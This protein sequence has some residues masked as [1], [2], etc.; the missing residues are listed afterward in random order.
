MAKR[1]GG[2]TVRLDKGIGVVGYGSVVGQKEGSGP[3]GNLFDEVV[4]DSKPL[5]GSWEKSESALQSAA[6]T[7]ALGRAGL[8]ADGVDM[9]FAGDLLNQCI[10]STFGL[11]SYGI[12]FAGLFGACSTMALS[13]MMAAISVESGAAQKAAAVTS[14]HFCTAERQFRTPLEYGGQRTPT[15]QWTTTAAGAVV[16]GVGGRVSV[17]D[18]CMGKIVD[19]G[20]SDAN[21]MGA[22]MAPAACDTIVSYMRDTGTSPDDYDAVFTGDLGSV[23]SELLLELVTA[24]GYTLDSK[25]LDCGKMIFDI[26]RQ[27]VH[28]GGSGCGC[29]ASVL[30]AHILPMLES[31]RYKNVLFCPTGAL[32]STTSGQQGESVPGI[33]HL[34]HLVSG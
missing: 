7:R 29:A 18:I 15:A 16:L 23:G 3:L 1:I 20:Q 26:E 2:R 17:S 5:D 6:L 28:A 33:A 24:E 25:H 10:G 27:D 11:R 22:A 30:C 12:P 14:S 13:M 31:G 4:D 34:L 32:M 8:N 19:L 21:N 9:I